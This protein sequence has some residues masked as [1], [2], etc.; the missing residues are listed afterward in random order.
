[1]TSDVIVLLFQVYFRS[2]LLLFVANGSLLL[3]VT[4]F[5]LYDAFTI[6]A[7]LTS[8]FHYKTQ[9]ENTSIK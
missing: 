2:D 7:L 5:P 9:L 8:F 4:T 6:L 3:F 1:M